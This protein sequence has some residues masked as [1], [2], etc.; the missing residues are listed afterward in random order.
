M[1]EEYLCQLRGKVVRAVS[2]FLLKVPISFSNLQYFSINCN[3]NLLHKHFLSKK[4]PYVDRSKKVKCL[5]G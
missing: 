3:N 2:K 4:C 1:A 5:T